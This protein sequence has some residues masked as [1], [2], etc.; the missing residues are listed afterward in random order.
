MANLTGKFNA[1]QTFLT[2][3]FEPVITPLDAI[4][5]KLDI[6]PTIAEYFTAGADG[7]PGVLLSGYTNTLLLQSVQQQIVSTNERLNTTNTRLT[8]INARDALAFELLTTIRQAIGDVSISGSAPL[9]VTQRNIADLLEIYSNNFGGVP[10]D[11]QFSALYYLS[12][13]QSIADCGCGNGSPNFSDPLG[14]ESPFT[15]IST[16]DGI[17]P[18]DG[19]PARNYAV[20]PTTL[21]TGLTF[22]ATDPLATSDAELVNSN[23]DGWRY[24]VQS[25][26]PSHKLNSTSGASYP[27]NVWREFAAG[28][29]N[30][31]FSVEQPFV[32]TVF[33]CTPGGAAPT[34]CQTFNTN[35]QL[36]T[37]QTYTIF[38][39]PGD[40]TLVVSNN[41]NVYE[42]NG[43]FRS[44]PHN[45]GVIQNLADR[46]SQPMVIATGVIGGTLEGL[47]ICPPVT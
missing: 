34:E 3:L 31:T 26:A 2:A 6:L 28:A 13:L 22:G 1:L 36:G 8:A 45:G 38:G 23:W 15:S 32:V 41:F 10:G 5:T 4:N 19:A 9:L 42:T 16:N 47:T 40:Y 11:A 39:F 33:I 7:F 21:P 46:G 44:G 12:K 37:N 29:A 24:Y 14:C 30:Y 17:A 25:T 18:G 35:G 43:A 27:N 20:F